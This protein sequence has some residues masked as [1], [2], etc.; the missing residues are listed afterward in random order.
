M[1]MSAKIVCSEQGEQLSLM[2]DD[3]RVILRSEDT[4]G[5][6]TLV[7][8]RSSPGAGVPLHVNTREDEVFQVLEGR[9]EFHVGDETVTA[10]AGTVVYAPRN[11][12]HAFHVVGSG[13]AL[14]QITMTPGGLEK[15]VEEII[16]VVGNTGTPPD[17]QKIEA[18]CDKFGVKFMAH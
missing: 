6:L 16:Q 5:Q 7:Q 2:G 8:Q 13:P 9:V 15:M 14:I 17:R 10:E 11:V 18:I 1:N 12:A 3:I 4:D